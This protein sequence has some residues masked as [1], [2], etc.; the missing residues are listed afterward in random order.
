MNYISLI[1]KNNKKIRKNQITF[2]IKKWILYKKIMK[3]K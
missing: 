3:R 1:V 2:M